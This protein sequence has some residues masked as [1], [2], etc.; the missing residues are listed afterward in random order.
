LFPWLEGGFFS[1]ENSCL[2]YFYCQVVLAYQSIV[3]TGFV[4]HSFSVGGN[5]GQSYSLWKHH[6]PISE[7]TLLEKLSGPIQSAASK[8]YHLPST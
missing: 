1:S 7:S 3:K 6:L 8:V 4:S 2:V 5:R